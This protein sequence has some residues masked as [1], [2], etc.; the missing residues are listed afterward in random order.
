MPRILIVD[1]EV[2][3]LA[4]CDK[5]L[6]RRGYLVET[7][8]TS[9]EAES[10]LAA[11]E[12]DLLIADLVMPGRNGLE[13][14]QLA[15]RRD[16]RLG[17]LII[18]AHATIETALRATREG[19]FDYIPKPFTMEQLEI[20]VERAIE[21]R[22]LRDENAVLKRQ[23]TASPDFRHIIGSSPATQQLVDVIR[24]VADTDA[25]IVIT[26]ESGTGKELVARAL[27][28]ASRRGGR[29]FVPVD[30]AAL[31]ETLLESELFGAERGAYTGAVATRAG[32]LE[33][34]DGGTL[35]LDEISNLAL[36]MQA[37]LLRVLQERSVRRLGG[38]REIPVDVRI[39]SATNQD[40]EHLVRAGRFREDLYYR[41]NVVSISTPPLRDRAGDIQLL[42]QHFV[43]E[44][45]TREG[46]DVRGLSAAA[47][48][49]LDRH[50][51]PGNV[52]ELRNVIERAVSLTESNQVMPSDLPSSLTDFRS[53]GALSGEFRS[54]KQQA[55]AE[56]ETA[57]LQRLMEVSGGNVSRAAA[58]A[59][60]KRTVLHRLL[61]RHGL[62]PQ[63]FRG[64]GPPPGDA[65]RRRSN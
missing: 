43:K 35:F 16:P 10:R 29:P 62:R 19:A 32:L 27:H 39:L 50:A 42:A 37:K 45:T 33:H 53:G 14:A 58:R 51:W 38:A 12:F 7:A 15:R 47:V 2:D 21:F 49:V 52:R 18:T 36:P 56:F 63:D 31:P 64:G 46:K 20:A 60:L 28:A 30:C 22:R 25:N 17:V 44:F 48:M 13:V 65:A 26:G 40:L 61:A 55:I 3:M 11:H 57:Y 9:E 41:L 34:A 5:I 4:T 6:S 23:V 54:A 24:K 59:G 8:S 1:D